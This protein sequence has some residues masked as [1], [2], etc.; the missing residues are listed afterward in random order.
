MQWKHIQPYRAR[1]TWSSQWEGEKNDL[2]WN[3]EEIH[4]VPVLDAQ[5]EIVLVKHLLTQG[6]IYLHESLLRAAERTYDFS[7]AETFGTESVVDLRACAGDTF[8]RTVF[9]ND[10][11]VDMKYHMS[12]LFFLM[13]N[14]VSE[15]V[16]HGMNIVL[17]AHEKREVIRA[18]CANAVVH[19]VCSGD[20]VAAWLQ[21]WKLADIVVYGED[22]MTEKCIKGACDSLRCISDMYNAGDCYC[23]QCRVSAVSARRYE[24]ASTSSY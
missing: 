18:A 13:H 21:L 16:Y 6:N 19:D 7:F 20:E 4:R 23:S 12:F 8:L 15:D 22:V 5:D 24:G 14:L 9:W 11:R 10:P 1:C 3:E 17:S 2:P